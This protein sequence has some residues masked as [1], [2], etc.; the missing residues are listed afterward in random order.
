[1]N[2]ICPLSINA[3]KM[4]AKV[5]IPFLGL[6]LLIIISTGQT[7]DQSISPLCPDLID[8]LA[9]SPLNIFKGNSLEQLKQGSCTKSTIELIYNNN[10]DEFNRSQSGR[11]EKTWMVKAMVGKPGKI[12]R[13]PN[14]SWISYLAMAKPNLTIYDYEPSKKLVF[15]GFFGKE[16][17][18]SLWLWDLRKVNKNTAPKEWRLVNLT[19]KEFTQ[20]YSNLF[21]DANKFNNSQLEKIVEWG[22]DRFESLSIKAILT[23]SAMDS[24]AAHFDSRTKLDVE[25]LKQA[26]TPLNYSNK[27]PAS[28]ETVDV[29][30]M[31]WYLIETDKGWY[32]WNANAAIANNSYSPTELPHLISGEANLLRDDPFF[33][34]YRLA[35]YTAFAVENLKP[36][37][38]YVNHSPLDIYSIRYSENS[39]YLF[40][41]IYLEGDSDKKREALKLIL[42]P[43]KNAADYTKDSLIRKVMHKWSQSTTSDVTDDDYYYVSNTLMYDLQSDP[44]AYDLGTIYFELGK[45]VCLWGWKKKQEE[46]HRITCNFCP[47]IGKSDELLTGITGNYIKIISTL[48]TAGS[49]KWRAAVIQQGRTPRIAWDFIIY[50]VDTLPDAANTKIV[51]RPLNFLVGTSINRDSVSISYL[52]WFWNEVRNIDPPSESSGQCDNWTS[53]AVSDKFIRKYVLGDALSNIENSPKKIRQILPDKVYTSDDPTIC[54]VGQAKNSAI[55]VSYESA[56][57][58]YWRY[59]V[60]ENASYKRYISQSDNSD[61]D[62]SALTEQVGD[63]CEGSAWLQWLSLANSSLKV[64]T[65]GSEIKIPFRNKTKDS[66]RIAF[67]L[68]LDGS[69][70]SWEGNKD[71]TFIPA[72]QTTMLPY[73]GHLLLTKKSNTSYLE[74]LYQDPLEN[75]RLFYC[76]HLGTSDFEIADFIIHTQ[77]KTTLVKLSSETD[78]LVCLSDRVGIAQGK[79]RRKI[80]F[81]EVTPSD[82]DLWNFVSGRYLSYS[83]REFFLNA[84]LNWNYRNDD[85]SAS[86][87]KAY[88]GSDKKFGVLRNNEALVYTYRDNQTHQRFEPL[89]EEDL[90]NIVVGRSEFKFV[91]IKGNRPPKFPDDYFYSWINDDYRIGIWQNKIDSNFWRANPLGYF[92]RKW[93]SDNSTSNASN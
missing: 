44:D 59:S 23:K 75:E 79:L 21:K 74:T 47:F 49:S 54:L 45:K 77:G 39:D 64:I 15:G 10:K 14:D 37:I 63:T 53:M 78:F 30:E 70:F 73:Q 13:S 40:K 5:I 16:H 55:P 26:F 11:I 17:Q 91:T 24:L 86:N 6:V 93:S 29:N 69:L 72:N 62:L 42:L 31:L 85:P 8:T 81:I 76:E 52:N 28:L 41:P 88:W 50:Q 27:R 89:L 25:P 51:Y 60:K 46:P 58:H 65:N 43:I 4:N 80:Y 67:L 84:T 32:V 82:K 36:Y 1:M 92:D 19:D 66:I 48:H 83:F 71:S 33:A 61:A 2:R 34:W 7:N 57:T 12:S 9:D 22:Y 35:N 3:N 56:N 38:T 87:L 20:R 68:K 18:F 90:T